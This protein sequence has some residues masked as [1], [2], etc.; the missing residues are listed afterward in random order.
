[1][2]KVG[3]LAEVHVQNLSLYCH[4]LRNQIQILMLWFYCTGW[5]KKCSRGL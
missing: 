1:M 3:S 2:M 5:G 4:C